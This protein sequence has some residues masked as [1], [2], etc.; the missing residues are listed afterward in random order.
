MTN[1]RARSSALLHGGGR[2]V[3][4]GLSVG[5]LAVS[6]LLLIPA[7]VDVGGQR[8]WGAIAVG[9]SIGAVGAV[10]I[11]FGW[12]HTGP[13]MIARADAAAARTEFVDSLRTRMLLFVPVT[14]IACVVAAVVAPSHPLL[15][16]A[17]CLSAAAVGFTS[18]W[19]FVGKRR[20]YAYLLLETVPRVLGTAVGILLLI[21]GAQVIAGPLC[22]LGGMLLGFAATS[23]WVVLR[24]RPPVAEPRRTVRRV[25]VAQRAGVGSAV[26]TSAYSALPLVLISLVAPGIQPAYALVDKLQRQLSV[27]LGPV[28]SVVQGYVPRRDP[29]VTIRRA[30]RALWAGAGFCAA[31]AAAVLVA[32][33]WLFAW[34]GAGQVQPEY[35]VMA[36]MAAFV[37]LNVWESILARAVLA[38]FDRLDAAARGTIISAVIG[39]PLVIA[40]AL[41]LGLVGAFAGLLVGLLARTGYELTVAVVHVRRGGRDASESEGA[42]EPAEGARESEERD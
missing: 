2:L 42:R 40:G 19:F 4:F 1:A 33:P 6:S 25:I 37:G 41:T 13:A 9:Q 16:A 15:S 12:G 28:V 3:G 36:L 24:D 31:L 23:C 29:A 7:M 14:T 27:A 32:A 10:M 35:A 39:L 38:S 11:Y 22:M 8:A 21:S 18:D 26:G 20:P 34:L 5:L 30:T 17:G